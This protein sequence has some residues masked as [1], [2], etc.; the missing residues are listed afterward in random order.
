MGPSKDMA[1]LTLKEEQL[2]SRNIS[3]GI[4]I[5]CGVS[6]SIG[7]DGML[8][9]IKKGETFYAGIKIRDSNIYLDKEREAVVQMQSTVPIGCQYFRNK[10]EGKIDTKVYC[11]LGMNIF[12]NDGKPLQCERESVLNKVPEEHGNHL[13]AQDIKKTTETFGKIGSP[14][15]KSASREK[16]CCLFLGTWVLAIPLRMPSTLSTKKSLKSCAR[17]F[18]GLP[19]GSI[20]TWQHVFTPQM[21][22]HFGKVFHISTT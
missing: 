9:A 7:V 18:A 4:N 11:T 1:D 21:P 6:A 22:G 14:F 16:H 20:K 19:D 5:R 12:V 13:C 10:Q 8:S 2:T 17:T 15:G 3:L